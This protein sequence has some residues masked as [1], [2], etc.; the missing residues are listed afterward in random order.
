MARQSIYCVECERQRLH[1]REDVNHVLHLIVS[2]F[3]CGLWPFVWFGLYAH[4]CWFDDWLC[5]S[6]GNAVPS[7][8]TEFYVFLG[9]FV[10]FVFVLLGACGGL[11]LLINATAS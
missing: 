9:I 6:C 2:L 11:V 8:K 3:C 5:T 4:N 1:E 10:V 7:N